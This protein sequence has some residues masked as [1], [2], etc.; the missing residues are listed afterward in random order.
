MSY[1]NRGIIQYTPAQKR[2]YYARLRAQRGGTTVV[3]G[4]GA[5]RRRAIGG[6][7]AYRRRPVGV[8]GRGAYRRRYY[9]GK[10][11]YFDEAYEA[12][13][14][15]TAK[16]T[17][18]KLGHVAG[19]AIS[20][21]MGFGAYTVKS[22]VLVQ[23]P[24]PMMNKAG[25]GAI[26]VRHREYIG[27]VIT[28]SANTF[29]LKSFAINPGQEQTFPWLSQIAANFEQYRIEGMIF[30][31]RS[32]SADA[33]NSTNTALGQVIMATDYNAANP[34]FG[35]KSEMENYDYGC[36]VKPSES[37][38]HP[39][40][41][42]RAQTVLS[43]LYTRAN[44][45]PSGEDVRLFDLGNF[46]I[47]TNGF[48]ASNVNVG[49]LW[50]SYQVTFL[51]QKMFAALGNY[52]TFSSWYR[53]GTNISVSNVFGASATV[54]DANWLPNTIPLTL[55]SATGGIITFP[56][57]QIKQTYICQCVWL[58]NATAVTG[59]VSVSLVNATAASFSTIPCTTGQIPLA[60]TSSR[61]QFYQ[62]CI[63]TSGGGLV[64]T[65]T[66]FNTQ[67][68][69]SGGDTASFQLVVTQIPNNVF[70]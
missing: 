45:V 54:S 4:R 23:D 46:Q 61:Y 34:S 47:A 53:S 18:G 62:F 38:I 14:K 49:E 59:T 6:R 35:Q 43:E 64:P 25:E 48:Q 60:S 56:Q 24:M 68:P 5:Y 13:G 52:N 69:G 9:R 41:C 36:S 15:S 28:G 63:Q 27:D 70:Q 21:F 22:N 7:G 16:S 40:E 8:A 39:I 44:A 10:G 31:Y 67:P 65:A 50:V 20:K 12:Y 2:A 66:V 17:L 42:A 29:N 3:V 51:K 1:R 11:G 19:D 55:T 30:E 26:T 37:M 58:G 57:S 32:M 33:L